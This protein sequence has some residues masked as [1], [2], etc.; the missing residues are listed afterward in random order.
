MH[1][2]ISKRLPTENS[3]VDLDPDE[4][5]HATRVLRLTEGATVEVLDGQGKAVRARL[6]RNGPR[7]CFEFVAAVAAPTGPAMT[8]LILEVAL[9]KGEAMEWVVEKAVEL[10]VAELV[11]VDSQNCT[12]KIEGKGPEHFQKRWQKIA[13]QAL[14]QCGRPQRMQVHLPVRLEDLLKRPA[15]RYLCVEPIHH[16]NEPPPL[17]QRALE[18]GSVDASND[19]S[20]IHVLVGPEGG[21][22]FRELSQ[23]RADAQIRSVSLGAL[24]LR[25]ETACL[26][27]ISVAQSVQQSL[28]DKKIK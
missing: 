24:T 9:L 1:R 3:N 16:T 23:M 17:L 26:F 20:S 2:F 10:G 27:A 18:V 25:A 6:I 12:L 4:A 15:R 14:K 21:W 28:L 11:P 5:K 22:S 7:W 13:D 8:P 19:S